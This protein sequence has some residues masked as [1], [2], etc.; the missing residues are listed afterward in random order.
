MEITNAKFKR[1]LLLRGKERQCDSKIYRKD[2]GVLAIF[3]L[4]SWVVVTKVFVTLTYSPPF[5]YL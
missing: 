5:P 4:F 3:S 1:L 2:L